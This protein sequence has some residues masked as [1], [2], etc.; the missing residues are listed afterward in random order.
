MSSP[1]PA[2]KPLNIDPR[3]LGQTPA[4]LYLGHLLQ[5]RGSRPDARKVGNALT[6][7]RTVLRDLS[8]C[9]LETGELKASSLGVLLGLV[10]RHARETAAQ[11]GA[12]TGEPFLGQLVENILVGEVRTLRRRLT[13]VG[14]RQRALQR[15]TPEGESVRRLKAVPLPDE[16]T[17]EDLQAR[18]AR[19]L[20]RRGKRNTLYPGG[21]P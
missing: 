12:S 14:A 21:T 2:P 20:A 16:K 7:V 3:T 10:E 6:A 19:Y 9:H 4:A 13:S 15:A 11:V 18:S 5:Q 1:R 17:P 8:A